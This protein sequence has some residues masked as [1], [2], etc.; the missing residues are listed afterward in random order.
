AIDAEAEQQDGLLSAIKNFEAGKLP[1]HSSFPEADA[2]LNRVYAA[3]MHR[4]HVEFDEAKPEG[5]RETQRAWLA[6]RDAFAAF[7]SRRYPQRSLDEWKAWAT[8]LRA[9]DLN[10]LHESP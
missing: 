8:A 5:I 4:E 2:E 7:A 9:A 1:E 10:A 6:Y 3:L